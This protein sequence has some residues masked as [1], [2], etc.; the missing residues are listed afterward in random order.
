MAGASESSRTS[1][2]ILMTR[3]LPHCWESRVFMKRSAN[4][5][6]QSYEIKRGWLKSVFLWSVSVGVRMAM[7]WW[8]PNGVWWSVESQ[9][10]VSSRELTEGCIYYWKAA[11]GGDRGGGWGCPCAWGDGWGRSERRTRHEIECGRRTEKSWA[12]SV[13]GG[14]RRWD[15]DWETASGDRIRVRARD[16]PTRKTADVC[17]PEL[18]CGLN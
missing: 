5:A 1:T 14:R 10:S 15:R 16:W 11:V 2:C 7:M 13:R 12:A 9:R 8:M 18:C 3:N 4:G 6:W 17:L